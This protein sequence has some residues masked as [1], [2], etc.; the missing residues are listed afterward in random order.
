[1]Q[2]STRSGS[3]EN[4]CNVDSLTSGLEAGDC[5][6]KQGDLVK[7]WV[8]KGNVE[9]EK[10]SNVKDVGHKVG[11]GGGGGGVWCLAGGL[12]RGKRQTRRRTQAKGFSKIRGKVD[13]RRNDTSDCWL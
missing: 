7:E 3:G 6:T 12:R 4:G 9:G 8:G 13:F 1:V 5:I 11:G 10:A 2:V